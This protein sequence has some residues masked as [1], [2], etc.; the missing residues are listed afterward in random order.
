MRFR[1]IVD[2]D[3]AANVGTRG[4]KAKLSAF[5]FHPGFSTLYLHR[6][7]TAVS[8]NG[9]PRLSNFIWNWNVRRSGCHLH[10]DSVIE[11]GVHFP[12]PI[13]IVVGSG[14]RIGKGSVVYQGV[15]LGKDKNEAYPDIRHGVT[16]FPNSVVVGGITV[17]ENATIG[18][19]SIVLTDVPAGA[20]VAG[21]PAHTVR[22]SRPSD[23]LSNCG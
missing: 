13:A 12:H 17:G 4:F 23:S 15:T 7:A 1:D 6:I 11:P 8:K 3:L 18:A 9:F 22:T 20:V 2:A 14:C 21:N 19:G 16:I 10:P 5:L